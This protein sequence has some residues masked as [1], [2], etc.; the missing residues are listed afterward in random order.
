MLLFEVLSIPMS[1]MLSVV[2]HDSSRFVFALLS[3][4]NSVVW[5]LCIGFPIYAVKRRYFT[6]AA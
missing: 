6:H 2:G 1:V 4:A 3:L 5:G